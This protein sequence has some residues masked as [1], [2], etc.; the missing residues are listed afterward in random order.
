MLDLGGGPGITGM[1]LIAAHPRMRGVI[2]DLPPVVTVTEAFIREYD[3]EDRVT[4]LGGDF[5]WN[6]IGEGY[7]LVFTCY[8]FV[9]THDLNAV[10]TKVYEALNPRGVFVSIFRFEQTHEGTK[11]ET[12]VLGLL[13]MALTGQ[14]TG[15]DHSHVAASMLRAGF[16]HV[17]SRP[18]TTARGL[19]ELTV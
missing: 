16:R 8:A 7:A 1:A 10:V 11:P 13:P 5:N 14:A 2:F 6:P 9:F 15:M 4:A 19:M 18:V 3:M 17:H 12:L